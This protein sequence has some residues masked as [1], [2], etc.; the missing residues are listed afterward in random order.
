MPCSPTTV[1]FLKDFR[2][3][4]RRVKQNKT[5]NVSRVGRRISIRNH[6]TDIM[7]EEEYALMSKLPH[8]LVNVLRQRPLIITGSGFVGISRTSQIGNDNAIVLRQLRHDVSPHI[9]SF[10]KAM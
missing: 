5:T 4:N 6:Q 10:S 9:P 8:Q 1:E 7:P 2:S 3:G